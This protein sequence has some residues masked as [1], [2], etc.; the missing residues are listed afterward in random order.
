MKTP[1]QLAKAV[2]KYFYKDDIIL[3]NSFKKGNEVQG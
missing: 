1:L 3:N 2:L